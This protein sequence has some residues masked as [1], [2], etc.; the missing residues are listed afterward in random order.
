MGPR[1][2]EDAVDDELHRDR[3]DQEPHHAADGACARSPDPSE[4]P[5]GVVQQQVRG[6]DRREDAGEHEQLVLRRGGGR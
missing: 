3:G 5:V 1:H 2:L 6:E 4:N